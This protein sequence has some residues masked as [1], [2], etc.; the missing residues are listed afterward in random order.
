MIERLRVRLPVRYQVV[1]AWMGDCLRTGKPSH[2]ITNTKNNSAF[3]DRVLACLAGVK[4][5]QVRA[6][7]CVRWQVTLCDLICQVTLRSPALGFPS[8]AIHTFNL[9][10]CGY[11]VLNVT[12]A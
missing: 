4:G 1:T 9:F 8:R 12:E 11:V 6:F 2:Y 7:T 3:L 5:K 10:L